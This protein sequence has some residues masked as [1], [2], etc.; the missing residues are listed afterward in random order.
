MKHLKNILIIEAVVCV[1]ACFTSLTFESVFSS[2]LAFPLEQLGMGLRALSLSGGLGNAAAVLL[3]N[4]L[5]L[6]PMGFFICHKHKKNSTAEDALL[7]LLSAALY[8][9]LYMM[10]NPG[11]INT[12][13][14]SA[15][16]IAGTG[17]LG[18]AFVGGTVYSIVV[19]YLILRAMRVFANSA[20]ERLPRYLSLLMAVVCAALVFVMFGS[21][22]YGLIGDIRQFVSDNTAGGEL[23][24]SYIFIVLQYL[25]DILPYAMEIVIIFAGFELVGALEIEPYSDE[26]VSAARKLGDVCRWAVAAIMLSQIAVNAAQFASGMSIRSSHY[27]IS[28]PLT[29]IL[30]ALAALLLAKY[31]EQGKKLKDDNDMFI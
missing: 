28:I 29:S 13:F 30:F 31:F 12:H 10:T 5:C 8:A 7:P 24:P 1:L 17:D 18:K 15:F 22:L 25:V 16:N 21:G 23:A 27:T 14:G 20:A 11:V 26:T 4:C 6:L 9:A 19:G 2:L 3:Y